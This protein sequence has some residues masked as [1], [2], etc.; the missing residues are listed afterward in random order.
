[1]YLCVY[2]SIYLSM[3]HH[4]H[5]LSTTHRTKATGNTSVV[6]VVCI[7]T[8]SNKRDHPVWGSRKGV[9]EGLVIGL[10]LVLGF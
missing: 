2:L 7:G 4:H 9:L 5:Y 3:C 6:K 1:M 10:D 8:S